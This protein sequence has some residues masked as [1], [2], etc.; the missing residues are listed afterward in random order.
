MKTL[1]ESILDKDY[2]IT[3]PTL[4]TSPQISLARLMTKTKWQ[5]QDQVS[6]VS[7]GRLNACII[8]NE[9]IF[10]QVQQLLN[11]IGTSKNSSEDILMAC[12]EIYT[13]FKDFRVTIMILRDLGNGKWKRYD[14]IGVRKGNKWRS[15][16]KIIVATMDASREW[17]LIQAARKK[18]DCS[19]PPEM[20]DWIDWF[21]ELN[22][23]ER[24]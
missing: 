6:G 10:S 20:L 7:W 4:T 17:N 24:K 14:I 3:I 19:I 9:N 5:D 2:D 16:C 22:K 23:F 18:S 21:I 15:F 12:T 1:Y 8:T 11:K 13:S